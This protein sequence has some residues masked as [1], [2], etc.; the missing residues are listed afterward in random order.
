MHGITYIVLHSETP[1]LLFIISSLFFNF[2][3]CSV[4][5]DFVVIFINQIF[6]KHKFIPLLFQGFKY[7]GQ[8]CRGVLG[9]VV[10]KHYTARLYFRYNS[11]AD[12]VGCGVL[13]PVKRV[14]IRN[15]SNIKIL[16]CW[17]TNGDFLHII[18][19]QQK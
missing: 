9:I 15:K 1:N 4:V 18:I 7:C 12:T 3:L 13:L 16:F 2:A 17:V 8:C 6:N 11:V 14:N 10:E 5:L 19:L